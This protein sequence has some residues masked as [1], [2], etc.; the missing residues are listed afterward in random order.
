MKYLTKRQQLDMIQ[1]Q[2]EI[3]RS[4]FVSHWQE[5]ADYVSPRR[6]RYDL[7]DTNRG[8]KMNQK[9]ID[10]TATIALRT[11]RSGMMSGITSPARPWF[12]LTLADSDLVENANV[13]R[14]LDD[15]TAR[16]NTAFLKS[17]LYNALPI[18]YGDMGLFGTGCMYVEE[19]FDGNVFRFQPFQIASY[20]L[21]QSYKLQVDTFFR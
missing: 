13:R 7:S 12:K 15:C 16:M 4:S 14:W 6:N 3:E 17:N 21:A 2:I 20:G 10:S 9:I 8:D 1:K 11:L 5:L 19:D 18:V